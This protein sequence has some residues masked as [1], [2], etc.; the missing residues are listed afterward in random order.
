MLQHIFQQRYQSD[1]GWIIIAQEGVDPAAGE[2][3][4]LEDGQPAPDGRYVVSSPSLKQYIDVR[5]GLVTFYAKRKVEGDLGTGT[6]FIMLLVF[7]LLLLIAFKI[8][9]R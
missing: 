4:S 3:V 7:V 8:I 2:A 9:G 5:E 6:T 1:K